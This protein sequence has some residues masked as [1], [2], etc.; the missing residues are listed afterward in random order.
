MTIKKPVNGG[1]H[2]L[3]DSIARARKDPRRHSEHQTK[4]K[5]LSTCSGVLF[6]L[7]TYWLIDPATIAQWVEVVVIGVAGGVANYAINGIAI[8]I[9]PTML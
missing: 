8:N 5:L 9:A 4:L 6:A 3:P 1:A 2:L 7:G